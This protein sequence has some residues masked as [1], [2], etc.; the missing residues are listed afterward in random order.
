MTF[1]AKLWHVLVLQWT[2]GQ[3]DKLVTVTGKVVARRGK[4]PPKPDFMKWWQD[5]KSMVG[6]TDPARSLWDEEVTVAITN[7]G[8]DRESPFSCD[9]KPV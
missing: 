8:G 7:A 5:I 4:T 3:Y 9:G 1:V 6:C 2:G